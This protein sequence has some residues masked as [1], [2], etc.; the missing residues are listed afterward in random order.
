M[1]YFVVN[2]SHRTPLPLPPNE[3]EAA[4]PDHQAHI[5]KGLTDNRILFAGPKSAG[6]GGFILMKAETRQELDEYIAADPFCQK[7]IMDY[8]ITEFMPVDRQ[9]YIEPWL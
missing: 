3:V 5:A 1:A 6:K 7:G 2:A 8:E 9:P 4:L